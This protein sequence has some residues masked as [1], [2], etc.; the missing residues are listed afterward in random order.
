[1]QLIFLVYILNNYIINKDKI[2]L[3]STNFLC[4][5]NQSKTKLHLQLT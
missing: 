5:Q 4:V 2:F 1:V 3:C